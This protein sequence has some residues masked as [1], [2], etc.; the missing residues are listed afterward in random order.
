MS[1]LE[2][3]PRPNETFEQY[4]TR[5][6]GELNKKDE[7]IKTIKQNHKELLQEILSKIEDIEAHLK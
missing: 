3:T 7:E 6:L 5:I 4:R 2:I 1:N